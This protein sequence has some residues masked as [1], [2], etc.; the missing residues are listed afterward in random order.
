MLKRCVRAGFLHVLKHLAGARFH[1]VLAALAPVGAHDEL[2]ALSRLGAT[3][4][5]D[6][7]VSVVGALKTCVVAVLS[8]S[9]VSAI[10]SCSSASCRIWSLILK[11][12]IM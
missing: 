11:L 7:Y 8:F 4:P 6:A 9:V 10:G 1:D 5:P 2:I 12:L 3:T